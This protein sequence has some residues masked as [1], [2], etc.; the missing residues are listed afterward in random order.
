MILMAHDKFIYLLTNKTICTITIPSLIEKM[1]AN[2]ISC[3]RRLK[4]ML[5]FH[6][7][8]PHHNFAYSFLSAAIVNLFMS[9]ETLA[10]N[11]VDRIVNEERSTGTTCLCNKS[12][13][14]IGYLF[15]LLMP[16]LPLSDADWLAGNICCYC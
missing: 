12:P 4:E 8:W 3:I 15:E 13:F 16:Q 10:N 14:K 11:G 1:F 9:S 5:H 6:W 2:D 7:K